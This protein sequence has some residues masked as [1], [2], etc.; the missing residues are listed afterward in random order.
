MSLAEKTIEQLN[1][2]FY[3]GEGDPRLIYKD[4]GNGVVDTSITG[5]V[6]LRLFGNAIARYFP[7]SK[8]TYIRHCNYP[9]LTTKR[10]LNALGLPATNKEWEE[11]GV[12]GREWTLV[13]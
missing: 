2:A 10:W 13:S 5:V 1:A 12:K 11:L 8:E 9:T 7:T 3:Q 4:L 6:T